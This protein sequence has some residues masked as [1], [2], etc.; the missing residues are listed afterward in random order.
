M[1][2]IGAYYSLTLMMAA[3]FQFGT[4]IVP[5]A[6]GGGQPEGRRLDGGD[7]WFVSAPGASCTDTCQAATKTCTA[8]GLASMQSIDS[9]T[10]V[11]YVAGLFGVTGCLPNATAMEYLPEYL[12]SVAIVI[13]GSGES[14][15]TYTYCNFITT[16]ITAPPTTSGTSPPVTCDAIGR[17]DLDEKRLCCCGSKCPSEDTESQSPSEAPSD[18]PSQEPSTRQDRLRDLCAAYLDEIFDLF[19]FSSAK[20]EAIKTLVCG[21]GEPV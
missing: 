19:L 20:E 9:E 2:T 11:I 13:V 8:E 6:P 14:A 16:S 15:T 5:A 7:D 17:T 1:K 12:P 10:K 18:K 4:A 21:V 3:K